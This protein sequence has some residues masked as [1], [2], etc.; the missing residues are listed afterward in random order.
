VD[1]YRIFYQLSYVFGGVFLL[2]VHQDGWIDSR[3]GLLD[4]YF[5]CETIPIQRKSTLLFSVLRG[6]QDPLAEIR[7]GR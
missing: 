2:D 6:E 3:F 5:L 7:M 4:L 1:P